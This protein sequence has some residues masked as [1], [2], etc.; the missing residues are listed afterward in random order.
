[1]RLRSNGGGRRAANHEKP[2]R[3]RQRLG[4]R[5]TGLAG[6]GERLHVWKL[7]GRSVRQEGTSAVCD[8]RGTRDLEDNVSCHHV[9]GS[10]DDNTRLTR[11]NEHATMVRVVAKEL[12]YFLLRLTLSLDISCGYEG[13]VYVFGRN[14]NEWADVRDVRVRFTGFECFADA[15]S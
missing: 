1:M 7:T 10:H 11:T 9:V 5:K 12:A 4:T 3:R 8:A 13:S 2:G 15:K 14:I 6:P